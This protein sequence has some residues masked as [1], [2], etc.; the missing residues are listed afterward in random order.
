MK[1]GGNSNRHQNGTAVQEVSTSIGQWRQC[2]RRVGTCIR[3][4][5]SCR[6]WFGWRIVSNLF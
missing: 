3:K 1:R 2:W 6:F 5:F 4:W